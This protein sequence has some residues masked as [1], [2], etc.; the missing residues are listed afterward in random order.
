MR[1]PEIGGGAADE[2]KM[3]PCGGGSPGS[4]GCNEGTCD[5]DDKEDKVSPPRCGDGSGGSE[6]CPEGTCDDRGKKRN[7]RSLD[8]S[9]IAQ[10]R[11]QLDQQIANTTHI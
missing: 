4:A 8:A 5:K 3:P 9:A 7:D 1:P 11:Q 10:L 2:K 6:G